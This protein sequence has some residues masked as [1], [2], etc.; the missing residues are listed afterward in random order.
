MKIL[1]DGE[2]GFTRI[3]LLIIVAILGIIAAVIIPNIGTFMTMGTV[4]AANKR[5]REYENSV[6]GLLCRRAGVAR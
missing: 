4:S 1:H 2:K 5:S 3:E 6:A